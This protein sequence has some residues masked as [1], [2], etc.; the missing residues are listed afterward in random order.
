MG[1]MCM[2]HG[3]MTPEEAAQFQRAIVE[4]LRT[5]GPDVR[6]LQ[7][8]PPLN[9][10]SYANGSGQAQD[11]PRQRPPL[12]TSSFLDGILGELTE[13]LSSRAGSNAH[14]AVPSCPLRIWPLSSGRASAGVTADPD[15]HFNRP[16]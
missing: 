15:T 5:A 6:G 16:S 4:I 2:L 9:R 3:L 11:R 14:P 13:T 8:P 10:G 12:P 1:Q 7:R